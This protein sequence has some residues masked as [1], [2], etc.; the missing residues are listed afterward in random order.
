MTHQFHHI[1]EQSSRLN[2][3]VTG[4]LMSAMIVLA[5]LLSFAPYG[6]I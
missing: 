2:T 4:A 5:G 1:P 6:L 3:F